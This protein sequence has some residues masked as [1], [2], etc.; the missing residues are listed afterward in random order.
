MANTDKKDT[1][2][3]YTKVDVNTDNPKIETW[4]GVIDGD[5]YEYKWSDMLHDYVILKNGSPLPEAQVGPVLDKMWAT[6]E[7]WERTE[8][9]NLESFLNRLNRVASLAGFIQAV[10]ET[11]ST[12][13]MV[14][15][16]ATSLCMKTIIDDM[17]KNL[18]FLT[19]DSLTEILAIC[20][21]E[22]EKF[23]TEL[24]ESEACDSC[25]CECDCDAEF[26]EDDK[27]VS[28]EDVTK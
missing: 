3:T 10:T 25:E 24:D 16:S 15:E 26:E 8:K 19:G 12:H 23:V 7:R 27:V 11:P 9:F 20:Q 22:G 14:V 13:S 5:E 21:K 4:K 2:V 1:G 28:L 6:I 18:D 17:A